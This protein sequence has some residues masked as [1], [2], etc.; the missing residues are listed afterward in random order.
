MNSRLVALYN[1]WCHADS[2]RVFVHQ[3]VPDAERDPGMSHDLM[4]LAELSSSMS[5]LVVWYSLLYVVIEG[6]I[7]IGV[8]DEQVDSLLLNEEMV[9]HLR[10][11]RNSVFHFQPELLSKKHLDFLAADGSEI[12]IRSFNRAIER[13]FLAN[14]PIKEQIDAL[15]ERAT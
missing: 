4:E 15:N 12:W 11:F 7:E 2:I 9:S 8:R 10:R 14:L 1:H 6:Y 3:P 13:F 5:R